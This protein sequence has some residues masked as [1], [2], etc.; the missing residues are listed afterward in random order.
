[1]TRSD[2][3]LE[4]LTIF[5]ERMARRTAAYQDRKLRTCGV[6]PALYGTTAETGLFGQDCFKM[7]T[8]SGRTL[9]GMVH[10][11]QRFE[12]RH[13]TGLDEPL[14]Q[15][16]WIASDEEDPRGRRIVQRFEFSRADGTLAVIAEMF[17]LAPDP[18]KMGGGRGTRKSAEDPRDGMELVSEK[19]L[20]PEDVTGFSED[21]GNLIHFNPEF[22]A[23]YGYHA[24]ISQGIQTMVWMM[25]ALARDRVPTSFDVTARFVRPV[26]WDDTATLWGRPGEAAP[27]DLLRSVNGEGKLTAELRVESIAY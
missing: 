3:A 7:I 15:R 20:R 8:A 19:T 26:Y 14:S 16:G 24:P 4:A 27:H 21:V 23:R 2:A 10:M 12:L 17:R 1:M 6:D 11:A 9:D 5:P 22:A 25:G 13:L 18:A